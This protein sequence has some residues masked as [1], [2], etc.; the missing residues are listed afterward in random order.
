[1]KKITSYLL[2]LVPL[3]ASGQKIAP[4][5]SDVMAPF[6]KQDRVSFSNPAKINYPETWFHFVD[7]NVEKQGITKDLE[8]IAAAGISGV[9]F[10]HGGNFGGGW[11]G[12][13]E[14]IYCLSDKWEDI[15]HYTASEANRLGL[16]F[17]MQN[18]PGWSMAGGP[19]ITPE[20][21][22]RVLSWT[23]TDVKG[24][25]MVSCDLPVTES[26]LGEDAD[27]KD[28]FVL[29]F[30][31]PLDDNPEAVVPNE[32]LSEQNAQV[33]KELLSGNKSRLTLDEKTP[34]EFVV[35]FPC[36]TILRSFV[37]NNATDINH[38]Y[39]C[40]PGIDVKITAETSDAGEVV[41]LDTPYP[42]GT[43][44]DAAPTVTFALDEV[45][46]NRLHVSI[47]HKHQMNVSTLRFLT[48]A[49]KNSWESEAGWDLRSIPYASEYPMQDS[50]AFI[51]QNGIVDISSC[52]DK[53][54]R[55][56]WKVPNGDW[57][58]LRVGHVNSRKKNSPAPNEATGWEC[59]KLSPEGAAA[60]FDGYIGKYNAGPVKGLL[61]GV[62]LDSWECCTQTWT[63]GMEEKFK[64]CTGYDLKPWIPALFGYVV[65]NQRT[66][67]RFLRDWRYTQNQLLVNNFYGEIAR[68][69]RENGL[70]VQYETCGG[71]VYPIDIMEYYKYADVPMTEFWHNST[72][73]QYVGSINFKP[74]RPAASAGHIYG[75]TR[76]S[77]EAFTSF[78]LTWNEHFWQL[79]ENANRHFAQGVSHLVFHTYTH[80]PLAD[81][82]I[83]GTS[84]G[85]AIGT[86]FLR[87]QTWWKF[88]PSF[89]KYLARC[90][91]ML[92]RGVP[93]FDV[94]WYL[95]DDINHKPDQRTQYMEG[96]NYDYCNRDVLLNRISV[97][98]G[99]LVTPEGQSYAVL[100]YPSAETITPE[101]L[102][103]LLELVNEGAVLVT[104][105]PSE[106]ATLMKY[107]T[108][109][110]DDDYQLLYAIGSDSKMHTVGKGRVYLGTGI[111][112]ALESEGIDKDMATP[113]VDWIHRRI[114]GADW[115]FVA[116]PEGS[117]F[118]GIL[119]FRNT[120]KTEIWNPVSGF[121]TEADALQ[122]DGRTSLKVSLE[123]GESIFVVFDHNSAPS[124][125]KKELVLSSRDISRG[126]KVSFPSG[127]GA[128]QSIEIDSLVPWKDMPMSEEGRSFSGTAVYTREIRLSNYSYNRHYILSLGNVDMVACVKVNGRK[129]DPVWTYPYVLDI[130]SALDNGLNTIEV[131]VT[132]GWFNRL[133]FDAGRD[134][135]DRRTWTI[136]GPSKDSEY[137]PTGLMGPVTIIE[138]R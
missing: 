37:M 98:N 20:N 8:A 65:G 101:T 64:S 32:L 87:G 76:V 45:R 50:A 90:T 116:A 138:K 51:P 38:G 120:G 127:W 23:R 52:M 109:Q 133:V 2:C 16:R 40:E 54:G 70:N 88:M 134:E 57:V 103:R 96:Y 100:W 42:Q 3:F 93:S 12:L 126:W 117:G 79:K 74:V 119:D 118:E 94:L 7:G 122:A 4:D 36:D 89:T 136:S 25:E 26:D 18:C 61:N 128:P 121:V 71:D 99:R 67:Y 28:L 9:Q 19:W 107:D 97:E 11:P 1:M 47:K 59:D 73:E 102:H 114:D 104:D 5:R 62:L 17:T 83:P 125:V 137:V 49:R 35:T 130:T 106:V 115:Y 34:L 46:T 15:L 31:R 24:G 92:E 85:S 131:E 60:H 82:L 10:F 63:R 43:W 84:F 108:K 44:Q 21:A 27:Y 55:L 58:V 77:A 56:S 30:K 53:S 6:G 66:T 78:W 132:S 124:K 68:K 86:P 39:C 13:K 75:K 29:A 111:V 123:R 112:E 14:H 91:Y 22:M 33:L 81:S 105:C 72:S 95:G 48:A 41:I 110:F 113:G 129:F 69:A 80:N 135:A